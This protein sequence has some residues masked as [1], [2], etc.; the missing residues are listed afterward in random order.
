MPS[1][2]TVIAPSSWG[3][4]QKGRKLSALEG[5]GR[6]PALLDKA[7]DPGHTTGASLSWK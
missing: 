3:C 4:R 1:C 6:P 7:A 5:N 2:V